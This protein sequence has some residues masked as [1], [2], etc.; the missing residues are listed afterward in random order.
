MS[1]NNFKYLTEELSSKNLECL[2]QKDAYPYEYMDS[3]TRFGEEKLPDRDKQ[4]MI[5]VKN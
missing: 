4:L 2:K 1:D 3:S 5:I